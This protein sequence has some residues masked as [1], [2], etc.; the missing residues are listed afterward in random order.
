M[1]KR[2]IFDVDNTLMKWEDYYWDTLKEV[3][4]KL[5]ITYTDELS[6]GIIKAIDT[7]ESE[8]QYYSREK[9]LLHINKITN[10]SFKMNFLNTMLECFEKCVPSNN[11]K[12]VAVLEYLSSKY[13]L[14]ILTN[15]FLDIQTH[16]LENFGINKYFSKIFAAEN[17][18]MKPDKESFI[19]AME[20]R[21]PSECIMIGDSFEK[22][23]QAANDIGIKAIYIASKILP[24]KE[25]NYIIINN[26]E[27][28][29]KIF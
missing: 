9:M 29:T 10:N 11:K 2:L 27:E 6:N 18:K 16:R 23:I 20:S 15:W 5:N 13:E 4:K 8:N 12:V 7:Y 1:I 14:V 22:D 21:K 19:T 28:L 25:E 17:F 3:C 26:L 24:K